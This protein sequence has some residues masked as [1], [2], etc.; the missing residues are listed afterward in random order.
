M[1]EKIDPRKLNHNL[2][3]VKELLEANRN[4]LTNE[5]YQASLAT[6]TAVGMAVQGAREESWLFKLLK[7][8]SGKS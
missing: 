5:E 4:L 2:K 6:M 3:E 1:K 8:C 7:T